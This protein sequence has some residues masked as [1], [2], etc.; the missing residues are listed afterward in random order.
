MEKVKNLLRGNQIVFCGGLRYRKN[1]TSDGTAAELAAYL[2]CVF[3]NLTNV[4]GLYTSN[5]KTNKKAKF[6]AKITWKK[7]EMIT[8]KIKYEA[9]QH[10]ILDQSA[11]KTIKEKKIQTQIVGSMGAI[12]KILKG[13][14]NFGGTF[15]EG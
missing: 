12:D 1:N 14:K 8:N 6:I 9:G 2:K 7:F 11:A 3:I 13:E 5:P 4:K 15:I 10:F